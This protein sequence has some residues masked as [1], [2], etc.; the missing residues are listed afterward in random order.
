MKVSPKKKLE[1]ATIHPKSFQIS[2]STSIRYLDSTTNQQ[3]LELQPLVSDFYSI[4]FTR[5]IPENF[6]EKPIELGT[7]LC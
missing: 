4:N 6:K 1:T 2:S 5:G 3:N 7:Q